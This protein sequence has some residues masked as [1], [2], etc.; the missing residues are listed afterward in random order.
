L[1]APAFAIELSQSAVQTGV[2]AVFPKDIKGFHIEN[3]QIELQ[4]GQFLFCAV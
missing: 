4:A 2:S 3:P 1:V